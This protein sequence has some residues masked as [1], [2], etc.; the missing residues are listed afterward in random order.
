MASS[1]NTDGTK[2]TERSWRLPTQRAHGLVADRRVEQHD[3]VVGQE[4]R[5]F[6]PHTFVIEDGSGR[7]GPAKGFAA[8][9]LVPP[10][11]QQVAQ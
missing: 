8:T 3:A 11:V 6:V 9:V 2:K 1:R 7:H 4:R 5:S 10:R